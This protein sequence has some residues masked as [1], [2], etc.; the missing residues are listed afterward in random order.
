MIYS[1]HIFIFVLMEHLIFKHIEFLLPSHNCVIIPDF[2]GFIVNMEPAIFDQEGQLAPPAYSIVFNQALKYNDGLL[3]NSISEAEKTGYDAACRK[4]KDTVNN[5]KKELL[6]KGKVHCGN[7]G[8]M[9]R[10]ENDNIAFICNENIK[11]PAYYGLTGMTLQPISNIRHRDNRVQKRVLK[12]AIGSVVAAAIGILVFLSPIG[13]DYYQDQYQQSDFTHTLVSAVANT[14][15][16]TTEIPSVRS[17]IIV[18]NINTVVTD[19]TT[20]QNDAAIKESAKQA[21]A[22]QE[23]PQ[24]TYYIVVGGEESPTRAANLLNKIKLTGF[25]N[26]AI[27]ESA[28]RYR[29]YIASFYNKQEAERYLDIFRIENPKYA[30]AWLYS[31]RN[32]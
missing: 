26:A 29:I 22:E 15:F 32:R 31:K 3:A 25:D 12:Y 6:L 16:N 27:V 14:T 4:I 10:D 17:G 9:T 21:D 2:G 1:N 13:F 30:S 5:I 11:H 28:D 23:T 8:W 7:M 20:L 24:R 18:D 19:S